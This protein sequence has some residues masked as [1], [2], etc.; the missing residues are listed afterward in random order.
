M[1]LPEL[2]EP[3]LPA[4][5]KL[6]KEKAAP[7]SML[8]APVPFAQAALR[9]PPLMTPELHPLLV[10][11]EL[12]PS[13]YECLVLGS[14]RTPVAAQLSRAAAPHSLGVEARTPLPR[15]RGHDHSR[16]GVPSASIYRHRGWGTQA[17]AC[18]G[19]AGGSAHSL[20]RDRQ[21]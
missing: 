5:L 15:G 20:A 9:H 13:L 17:R 4:L 7:P 18:A 16:P 2:L 21:G 12:P 6:A 1:L 19:A 8:E 11:P 3:L 10:A 14:Y